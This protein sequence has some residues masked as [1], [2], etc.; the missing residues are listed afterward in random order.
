[1]NDGGRTR[2]ELIAEIEELRKRLA[3]LEA[4]H[5]S[6]WIG[7][8]DPRLL[9][10]LEEAREDRERLKRLSAQGTDLICEI[11]EDGTLLYVSDN[12]EAILGKPAEQLVGQSALEGVGLGQVHPAQSI[13][14]G[15]NVHRVH[16]HEQITS[17]VIGHRS[18][19][20]PQVGCPS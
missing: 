4:S 15:A 19:P 16:G 20:F 9:Q 14:A 18:P 17:R 7:D 11:G 12:A 6:E 8:G 2:Q 5:D 3:R 13:A 10:E 1:M